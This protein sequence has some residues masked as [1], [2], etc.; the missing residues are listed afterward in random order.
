[1]RKL[2][3][4]AVSGVVFV[5]FFVLSSIAGEQDNL[6]VKFNVGSW[7]LYEA[8]GGVNLKSTLI[9]K[10]DSEVTLRMDTTINGDVLS[11]QEVKLPLVQAQAPMTDQ[12]APM[13]TKTYD[14]TIE[15]KGE[16][17]S[18]KVIE[19]N[20][21]QGFVKSWISDRVPGGV[22]KSVV[23]GTTVQKAVDYE[24]K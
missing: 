2:L 23:A 8:G 20:T 6:W 5:S 18:C 11:S 21:P 9:D 16:S 13:N 17:L 1:M 10:T 14:D 3:T 15:L 7:V 22:V 12:A 24:A 19:A 4:I